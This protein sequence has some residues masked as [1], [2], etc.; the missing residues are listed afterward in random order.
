MIDNSQSLAKTPLTAG[1][2]QSLGL[3]SKSGGELSCQSY[4]APQLRCSVAVTGIILTKF[5]NTHPHSS[6]IG[7]PSHPLFPLSLAASLIFKASF[8]LLVVFRCPSSWDL[9]LGRGGRITLATRPPAHPPTHKLNNSP[10]NCLLSLCP[11]SL[12]Y[13]ILMP[14]GAIQSLWLVGK[15]S[16]TT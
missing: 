2:T 7:A 8:S 5:R 12:A 11:L 16:R 13:S 4:W 10:P 3:C 15:T 6:H 14:A 9:T 1:Q